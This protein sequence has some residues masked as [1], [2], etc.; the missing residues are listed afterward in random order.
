M[1]IAATELYDLIL[2]QLT[3]A[4]IRVLRKARKQNSM[5]IFRQVHKG[6]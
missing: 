6:F 1:L 4:F 2:I 3:L 5:P